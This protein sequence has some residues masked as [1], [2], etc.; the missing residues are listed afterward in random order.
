LA[1]VL[2]T[3]LTVLLLGC[4]DKPAAPKG[5]EHGHDE[6][7]HDHDEHGHEHEDGGHEEAD[8]D[9]DGEEEGGHAHEEHG[10][11]V[12]F[13]S[14]AIQHYGIRTEAASARVLVPTVQ[15]PAQVA[16]NREGI[17]HVGS[18]VRGRVAELSVKLGQ[19]V[20]RGETL[21]IVESPELGEAQSEYL[22]KRALV[23]T[24][25][26]IVV[27]LKDAY[28]RAR[29]LLEKSQGITLTEV[30]KREAEYRTAEAELRNA[31]TAE[32]A[33]RNRL[34]LLAMTPDA[35]KRLEDTGALDPR[36]MITASISGQVIER[37]ATLGEL[38]GPDRERLLSLADMTKL[39][40]LAKVPEAKLNQIVVGAK[41]RLLLGTAE[42]HRC[43]GKVVYVSP[44]LDH[45][46]RTA[47]VR[48][49]AEDR[50]SSADRRGPGHHQQPGFRSTPSRSLALTLR[51]RE[52]GHVPD[53]ERAR[54]HPRPRIHALALAQRLLAGHGGLR[55]RRETSTSRAAGGRAIGRGEGSA[56]A[57]RRDL[58]GPIATGLGEIYMY[59]VEYEHP[60]GK[61]AGSR[62]QAGLAVR[63]F[64]PHARGARASRRTWSWPPT[65][66]RCRTGSSGRSSRA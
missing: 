44:S 34:S 42:D 64:V 35:I 54:G 61:G 29:G 43:E 8:H 20:T 39:W 6:H 66:A 18:P 19:E 9:A 11:E 59:T 47:D 16:F 58:M 22:Q 52:A 63:R 33:V 13:S 49:E 25:G 55:R 62:R 17:A 14:S 60:H 3:I 21:L 24:A 36:F 15:V 1:S 23:S 65:C 41:A 51:G 38:V 4:G 27:L 40:V 5:D 7:G 56:A 31:E 26:P 48:I 30:Q 53:G 50:H 46:T 45:R 37:E 2:A 32:R 57:G 28:E 10:D 12:S